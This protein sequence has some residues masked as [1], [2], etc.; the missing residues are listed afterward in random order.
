MYLCE[1]C[2]DL[3][4]AEYFKDCLSANTKAT[5]DGQELIISRGSSMGLEPR[6]A[7]LA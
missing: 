4:R 3:I 7:P 2:E 6:C 1:W 5:E